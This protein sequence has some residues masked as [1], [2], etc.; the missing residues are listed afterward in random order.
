MESQNSISSRSP[1][2]K[3]D[4]HFM[5]VF[6]FGNLSVHFISSFIDQIICFLMFNLRAFLYTL[7]INSLSDLS[8]E[9]FL[10]VYFCFLFPILYGISSHWRSFSLLCGLVLNSMQSPLPVLRIIP[11]PVEPPSGTPCPC[12]TFKVFFSCCPPAIPTF[13]VLLILRPFVHI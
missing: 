1:A 6:P 12:H 8:T 11:V 5:A 7:D 3:D 4:A 9:L 13:Q 10:F 2:T